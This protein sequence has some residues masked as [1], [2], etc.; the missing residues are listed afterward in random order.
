MTTS[1]FETVL[2][3]ETEALLDD[4]RQR[5]FF[6]RGELRFDPTTWDINNGRCDDFAEAVAARTVGAESVPASGFGAD[7][8]HQVVLFGGRFYDAECHKGVQN[9]MDLPIA[10]NSG[11][12][13]A[14][15]IV[16]Q[17]VP[18]GMAGVL[19]RDEHDRRST[20]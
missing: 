3:E 20:G 10:K 15:V 13:H 6:Y 19:A 2:V 14:D 12:L 8:A 18:T 16:E 1:D 7:L 17:Q 11:R 4:M 5:G 9:L